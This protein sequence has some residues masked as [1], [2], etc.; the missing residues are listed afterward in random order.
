MCWG[1]PLVRGPG[2]L[3]FEYPSK[4][5]FPSLLRTH[6][7]SQWGPGFSALPQVPVPGVALGQSTS[8]YAGSLSCAQDDRNSCVPHTL[9]VVSF[10]LSP[11]AWPSFTATWPIVDLLGEKASRKWPGGKV[12]VDGKIGRDG[13]AGWGHSQG[14]HWGQSEPRT[15]G[16]KSQGDPIL[17]QVSTAHHRGSSEQCRMGDK[18]Y[19]SALCQ[20]C[21]PESALWMSSENTWSKGDTLWGERRIS[22]S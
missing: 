22:T 20:I 4:K 21:V 7:C 18:V 2:K 1:C 10:L 5:Y 13:G 15:G 12:R 8:L 6:N 19:S 11:W 17:F 9:C 16:Q 3:V 14:R